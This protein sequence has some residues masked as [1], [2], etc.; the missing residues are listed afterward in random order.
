MHFIDTHTHLYD[1]AFDEDRSDVIQRTIASGVDRWIFPAIDSASFR[2][3]IAVYEQYREHTFMGM[4]LHPTSVAENWK[5]EL[6][7]ALDELNNHKDRYIAVGEIGLDAYWSRDFFSQ[8]KEVLA[9]QLE[10][11]SQNNLPV[12]IH[13]RSATEDM[14]EIV[15]AFK[16]RLRGVFHAFT[17]SVETYRRI[18]GLGGFKVGIGGVVTF[19]NAGIAKTVEQIPLEDILLET[20]SPYLTPAPHRGQRNESSYIP[21]IAAKIAEIKGIGIKDVA[22]QTTKNAEEL[23]GLPAKNSQI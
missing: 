1:E 2:S 12:I 8:Q 14:L 6:Q 13:E 15:S 18:A 3:Q 4:G 7:F 21:L 19:K 10:Y 23:F 22:L 11:A 5:E 9:T 17:G 20:D 16:G